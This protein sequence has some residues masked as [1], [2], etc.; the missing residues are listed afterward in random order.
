[1]AHP[2]DSARTYGNSDPVAVTPRTPNAAAPKCA[3]TNPTISRWIVAPRIRGVDGSIGDRPWRQDGC[4]DV[5]L[6]VVPDCPS[7]IPAARLVRRVLDDFGLTATPVRTTVIR[8]LQDAR[9]RGFPGSPT[10]LI[11]GEDP[12][13]EPGQ[14]PALACRIYRTAAGVSGVP[15]GRALHQAIA[16]AIAE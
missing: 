5:E 8:T 13:G 15:S 12:F 7:E 2:R 10:V 4:V 1:M 16:A 6:L 9:R 14:E 3:D 11:D